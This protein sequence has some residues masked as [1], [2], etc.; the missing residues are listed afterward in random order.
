MDGRGRARV[1]V[2]A[3]G[4][5]YGE[6]PLRLQ[7]KDGCCRKRLGQGT[8]AIACLH[9]IGDF[10]IAIGQTIRVAEEHVGPMGDQ[11]GAAKGALLFQIIKP[12]FDLQQHF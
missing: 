12:G 7:Y 5:G 6:F 4:S 11:D 8:N 2:I 1:E 10:K 3:D 9:R